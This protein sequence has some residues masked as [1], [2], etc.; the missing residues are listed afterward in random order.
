MND[1]GRAILNYRRALRYIPN[2]PNLQQNLNYARSRRLDKIEVKARTR[3]L[4]TLLFWHYD[5]SMRTRAVLF[6]ASF[7]L[8]W[9]MLAFRLFF[10]RASLTWIAAA[11]GGVAL[12][13][14][15]SVLA[16]DISTHR[17][18]PGVVVADEV[19][20]RKGDSS[21][22][23]PSFKEPLHA[24]AEFVLLQRRGDWLYIELMDGRR[25]W[26]PARSA[27]WIG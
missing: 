20:A 15:T 8:L 23:E 9:I 25:C 1:L 2:D 6:T 3:I 11:L 21:A 24:G 5:F 14:A 13:M 18:K 27:E 19:T 22:Y 16:Q 7:V 12:L 10:R 26:I 17:E 4:R